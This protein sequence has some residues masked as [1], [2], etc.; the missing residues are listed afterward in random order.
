MNVA[1]NTS[2]KRFEIA[3][4]DHL[5]VAE[6][7]LGDGTITFT[8]TLVP[9]ELG[10]QGLG[11]ALVAAGLKSA[12]ERGLKVIP[13]CPFFARHFADHPDERDLLEPGWRASQ[14]W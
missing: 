6:Y 5:A 4:G 7:V 13:Q 8:H 10:G 9:K 11:K 2:A 3:V 12:R 14:G 1:D